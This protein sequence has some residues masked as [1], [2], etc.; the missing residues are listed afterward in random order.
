MHS[1]P[2]HCEDGLIP[3]LTFPDAKFGERQT[4]WNLNVLLYKDGPEARAD[5]VQA[6]I[7]SGQI[8]RPLLERLPLV[9]KLHQVIKR[10]LG[11]GGASDSVQQQIN[12]LRY[13]FG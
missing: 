7:T 9:V 13:L 5:C 6:M 10:S 4:P 3:D 12:C 8:G 11:A 2:S 1:K